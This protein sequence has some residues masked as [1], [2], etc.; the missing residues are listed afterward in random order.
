[1][2]AVFFV[3]L[4][5]RALH[6]T[7][8]YWDWV[9][10]YYP[11]QIANFFN[12]ASEAWTSDMNGSP[13]GYSTDY[14]LRFFVSLFRFLPP[15]LLLFVIL[16]TIFTFTASIVY[17]IARVHTKRVLAFL[18]GLVAL[19]NPIIF[20]NFI[21]G[22]VDYLVGYAAFAYLTYVLLYKFQPTV[23]NAVLIGLVVVVIGVQI[24]LFVVAAIF[25]GLYFVFRP[26]MWRWKLLPIMA[27]LP[28]LISFVWLSNFLFGGANLSAISGSAAK[29]TFKGLADSNYLNIFSFSFSKATLISRFYSFYELLLYGML[30]ALVV[31]LLIRARR[32]Q[33]DDVFMLTFM[34]LML[35]LATGLFQLINLGPVTVLYP[36]FREVGH[37]APLILL[38]LVVLLARLMSRGAIKWLCFAWLVIVIMVS[39]AKYRLDTQVVNFGDVRQQFAEFKQFGDAHRGVDERVLAYPYFDQYAFVRFP[40]KFQNGLPLK[41]SG[42]DSF[43]VFSDQQFVE[44]AVKPQDFKDSLQYRLLQT[45]DVDVLRPYNVHYIYDF[46]G[47]YESYYDRYVAPATYDGDLSLIKNNPDFLSQLVATN[48]GKVKQ[49]SPH[50]LEI[51]DY[52]PRVAAQDNLYQVGSPDDGETARQFMEQTSPDQ[53]FNYITPE[54]KA[55]ERIY[56]SLTPVFANPATP[57]LVDQQKKSLQQTLQLPAGNTKATIYNN[58]TPNAIQYHTEGDS[59]VFYTSSTGKLYANDQLILDNDATPAKILGKAKI[60][61]GIHYFASLNGSVVPVTPGGSGRIGTVTNDSTL[62]VFVSDGKNIIR[63]PS[64][65]SGLWQQK[66]DDCNA[67]DKNAHI[68][69][70]LDTTDASDGKQSLELLASRH[71]ACTYTDFPMSSNATYV[72]SYDYKGQQA[73]SASFYVRFNNV[74]QNAI[75]S[76]QTISDTDWHKTTQLI[77]TP[78]DAHSGQI[79]V[80]ATASD[81]DQPAI[82]HYDNFSLLQLQEIGK[83]DIPQP[84]AHYQTREMDATSTMTLRYQD[85]AYDFKNVVK[86]GSFEDGPWQTKVTDCNKYDQQGSIAAALSSKANDGKHSLQL[87]ATRHTACEYANVPIEPDT[88][89]MLSFDYQGDPAQLAGYYME[90]TGA[91][92]GKQE[93][94]PII[95]NSWHTFTTRMHTPEIASGARLY[96][97]A[98]ESNGT[99]RNVVRFDNVKLIAIPSVDQQF[100][101]LSHPTQSLQQPGR[102]DFQSQGPSRKV[103]HVQQAKGPFIVSLSENYHPAWRLELNNNRLSGVNAWRPGASVDAVD[104]HFPLNG[105]A[106]GWYVDPAKLCASG[107]GGCTHRADGSY[108]IELVAEFVPQR[109]LVVSRTV[110]VMS[111]MAAAGYVAV[112]HRR[113]KRRLAEE[114]VYRHP[115]VMKRKKK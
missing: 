115:L 82:V 96:L 88:D 25:I 64:F 113:H 2:Y 75:R 60:V 65:E 76:A 97:H 95:D 15:E 71:D 56:G 21:A 50:I 106:N 35:F 63:N 17:Q 87:E 105:Y 90:F 102:V 98:Y 31:F 114:G 49:V 29:A 68:D 69:M 80:H 107:R 109:W 89:Y 84:S 61:K 42:H 94:M 1:L 10:P 11:D 77:T 3:L 104:S 91:E 92:S 37:F 22:Y 79:T 72:L 86:N 93:Q 100:F 85:E 26:E 45:M 51:T 7:G 101:V 8:Q 41:N 70:R 83:L 16:V 103:V 28:L 48:P 112:T 73:Q 18:L 9:F 54:S 6:G 99:N 62:E 14:F 19:V 38:C 5:G 36:M 33:V 57:H 78:E 30:F 59:I 4:L 110:S 108:D 52:T 74:D 58:A 34:L 47:I 44:N 13:L 27:G 43:T 12:R 66:A 67:Y 32:K 39:F 20:Y 24:Q 23:R 111:L 55:P 46:S 40:I 53:T 81:G